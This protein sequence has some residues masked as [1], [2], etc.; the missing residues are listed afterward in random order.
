MTPQNR[1]V[2]DAIR[3]HEYLVAKHWRQN[4]LFGPDPGIRLNYRIGRFVK[5]YLPMIPWQDEL[6]YLQGQ[7]YWVLANWELHD[8]TNSASYRQYAL[9]CCESIVSTQE[10]DGFWTY[11]NPEWKGRVATVEGIWASLALMESY[12]RTGNE[13]WLNPVLRW[14]QYLTEII[15]FQRF[16]DELAINYFANVTGDP[17]PNNST[18]ALRFFSTLAFVTENDTYAEPCRG[19]ITF[20][21]R[22]QGSTGEFPYIASKGSDTPHPR[23][24]FQCYQYNAFMCLSLMRYHEMTG[25]TSVR[26][27]ISNVLGFLEGGINERGAINYE[28]GNSYRHVTYHSAV[29]AAAFARAGQLGFEGYERLG[30]QVFDY[31]LHRQRPDGSLVYSTGD[32]RFLSDKRSYPRYLAM[33]LYHLLHSSMQPA[34]TTP[35]ERQRR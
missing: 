32:Y 3:V 26:S 10:D 23:P 18:E 12:R 16:G 9:D 19:L 15:G 34:T 20:L 5:S 35:S 7:G 17:T 28:C 11:P 13:R 25:D 21:Q 2:D 27:V 4:G 29:V 14:H 31:V 33:I 6:Y 8:R 1:Y 24:H 30:T 22:V